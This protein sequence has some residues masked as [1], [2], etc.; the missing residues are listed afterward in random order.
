M[1]QKDMKG[2]MVSIRENAWNKRTNITKCNSLQIEIRKLKVYSFFSPF[3]CKSTNTKAKNSF[4]SKIV[5]TN[6]R[7]P[8]PR[9]IIM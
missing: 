5:L 9:I 7:R 2:Q 6:N 1:V 3:F 4:A 8:F